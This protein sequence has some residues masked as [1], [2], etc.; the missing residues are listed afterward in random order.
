VLVS[1]SGVCKVIDFGIARIGDLGHTRAG[2]AMG[3]EGY[4]APEQA[5]DASSVDARVDVYGL[6]MTLYVLATGRDP[7]ERVAGRGLD[8]LAEPLRPVVE[9]ATAF[10][11]GRRPP[12]VAAF[13]AELDE[14]SLALPPDPPGPGLALPAD[15]GEDLDLDEL[16]TLGDGRRTV[17]TG[18]PAPPLVL[19]YVV[20]APVAADPD[21]TPDWIADEPPPAEPEAYEISVDAPPELTTPT[22]PPARPEPAAGRDLVRVAL[23][24]ALIGTV[25]FVIALLVVVPVVQARNVRAAADGVREARATLDAKVLDPDVLEAAVALGGDEARL[26]DLREAWRTT[27]AEPARTE[28]LERWLAAVEEDL[29]RYGVQGTPATERTRHALL[30]QRLALGDWQAKRAAYEDRAGSGCLTP[31]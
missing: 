31:P 16:S 12:D 27:S 5:R 10:D 24:S 1:S 7:I 15:D 23:R 14:A 18:T 4:M 21:H 25:V 17:D 9:R 3:T 20:P 13:L 6:G 29:E 19:P 11:P 28:A 8:R 2:A 26:R 30:E 22:P